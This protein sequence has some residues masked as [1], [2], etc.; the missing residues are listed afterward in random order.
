MGVKALH[1]PLCMPAAAIRCAPAC[2]APLS[3]LLGPAV[4]YGVIAGLVSYLAIHLPFWIA[5]WVRK[6]FWGGDGGDNSPRSDRVRRRWA[7]ARACVCSQ[8]C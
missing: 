1:A 2:A 8:R 6:R 3:P 7:R 5:D 4:A